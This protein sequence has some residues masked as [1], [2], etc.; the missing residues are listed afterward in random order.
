MIHIFFLRLSYG[1]PRQEEWSECECGKVATNCWHPVLFFNRHCPDPPSAFTEC[2]RQS[3]FKTVLPG[4]FPQ[5]TYMYRVQSSVW[6]LPNYW[7]PESVSSPPH[8]RVHTRRAV[9]GWWVN[10]SQDA[11]NWI[12][13]LQYNPSTVVSYCLM[14][15]R[16]IPVDIII[17]ILTIDSSRRRPGNGSKM[18]DNSRL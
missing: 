7:P 17:I 14:F 2:L 9:R 4:L 8:Q 12:G 1:Q 13:L 15:R 3:S 11:S 10:I 5:S 16:V 6:R 18:F